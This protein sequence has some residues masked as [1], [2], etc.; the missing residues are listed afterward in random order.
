MPSHT[1]QLFRNGAILT[2]TPGFEHRPL[3]EALLTDTDGRIAFVGSLDDARTRAARMEAHVREVDLRGAALLPGLIDAHSHFSGI[4]QYFTAADLTDATSVDDIVTRLQ[5]FATH[6]DIPLDNGVILGVGYDNT[7]LAG[8]RHPTR[9]DLDKVTTDVPV[10]AVHVSSHMIVANSKALAMAGITRD[11]PDPAGARFGREPDGTP[12]GLCQEPAAM[13][14]VYRALD[15]RMKINPLVLAD[16]M[17]DEYLS[18]GITTAQDG[19]TTAG[20]ADNLALLASARRLRLDAVAYPMHG[21]DID[22]IF[23]RHRGYVGS[24]YVNHLR[25]GGVKLILDGSPQ[26]RTAWVS[27][28]YAPGPEGDDFHGNQALDDANVRAFAKWAIDD[29]LQVMAHCNGDAANEQFLDEYGRAYD[30]STN[31]RKDELR[32]VMIH[33]QLTRRDQLSRFNDYHMIPSFFV[34][35]CWYW[36]DVHLKNFGEER[37]RRISAVRDAADFALPY[38]FHTDSPIIRPNLLEAVWCAAARRTKS[39][40]ELN[41]AQ[42][43]DVVDGLR[44]ITANAAY[45]YGEEHDKGTLEVGKLADLCV[46]EHNPLAVPL[47]ADGVPDESLRRLRVLRT[48]KSGTQIWPR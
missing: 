48:Y 36:G 35:H 32:P 18:H 44:A 28:P 17:Q 19:A 9:H 38:T 20:W 47:D 21:Q 42:R 31:A 46:L 4:S 7:T 27:E 29:G 37:G 40:V 13:F 23:D 2:M 6:S 14:A 45:Q 43:V 33:C 39:G 3:P 30:E 11:T 8:H 5:D 41:P 25:F 16:A 26:G 12:D 10:L 15:S 1:P 24:H 22:G 34:S